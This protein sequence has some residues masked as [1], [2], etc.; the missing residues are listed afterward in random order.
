[1]GRAAAAEP[2]GRGRGAGSGQED[3]ATAT[4]LKGEGEGRRFLIGGG[5]HRCQA[6]SGWAVNAAIDRGFI[7][8]P[9]LRLLTHFHP[10]FFPIGNFAV[11]F[12]VLFSLIAGVVGIAYAIVGLTHLRFWNYHSLQ[13]A[14]V[15]GLLVWAL[16]VLAMLYSIVFSM[17]D[18]SSFTG[19]HVE[20]FTIILTV[21][22][23]FY[24]LAIHGGCQ[25]AVPVKRRGNFA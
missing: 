19:N 22:Q 1:M 11:G 17:H 13:L 9:E 14:A 23:F 2:S 10:I 3:A 16:T 4:E 6:R 8:G 24:I 12:F 25:G 7:V 15:F 18:G 21:M 20:A 5:R